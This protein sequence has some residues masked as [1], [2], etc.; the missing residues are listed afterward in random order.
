[1]NRDQLNL[2]YQEDSQLLRNNVNELEDEKD[3]VKQER[4][5]ALESIKG[6]DSEVAR[7]G[8]LVLQQQLE[9]EDQRSELTEKE[10]QLALL[11]NSC[12]DCKREIEFLIQQHSHVISQLAI[13]TAVLSYTEQSSV[14]DNEI[15]L[16][17]SLQVDSVLVGDN[18]AVS[19]LRHRLES[20]QS[21]LVATER[22]YKGLVRDL[23]VA[24][25]LRARREKTHQKQQI[26]LLALAICL[27]IV[28]ISYLIGAVA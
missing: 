1:M 8:E 14:S 12:S 2:R 6:L 26:G 17:A 10:E 5:A 4:D 3:N 15:Q 20:V 11:T 9:L 24:N 19:E 16:A 18:D 7:Q 27:L 28:I 25:L 23:D 13:A 22:N 21:Q